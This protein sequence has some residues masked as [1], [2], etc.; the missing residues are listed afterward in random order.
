MVKIAEKDRKKGVMTPIVGLLLAVGLFAIAW[1]LTTEV[2]MKSV[3][4]VR[5]AIAALPNPTLGRIMLSVGI[6]VF[7]LALSFGLVA[8]LTGKDPEKVDMPLPPRAS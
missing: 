4:Q 5:N 8:I 7:L 1:L 2:L 3:S 6:W